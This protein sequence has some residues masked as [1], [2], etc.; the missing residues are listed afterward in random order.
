MKKSYFVFV[1]G[2]L[3]FGSVAAVA[4]ETPLSGTPVEQLV[5]SAKRSS[6]GK[7]PLIVRLRLPRLFVPEG[8]LEHAIAASQRQAILAAGKAFLKRCQATPTFTS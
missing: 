8:R 6:T 4:R 1:S 3:V 7:I 2:W 5:R